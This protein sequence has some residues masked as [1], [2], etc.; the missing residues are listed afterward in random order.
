MGIKERRQR[1][2]EAVKAAI[3]KTSRQMAQEKGWPEVSIR[4]IAKAIE[5][6][7]PVIYEHFKNRE[8]ILIAWEDQGFRELRYALEEARSSEKEPV[9][10]LKALTAK[11]WDWAFTNRE[12]YEIMFN[13]EGAKCSPASTKSLWDCGGSVRET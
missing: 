5:Y 10:Q 12:L 4:K 11:I 9:A 8:A 3:M 6:T 13:L 2:I 1:E 7:P